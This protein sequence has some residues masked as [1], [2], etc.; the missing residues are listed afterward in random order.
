MVYKDMKGGAVIIGKLLKRLILKIKKFEDEGDTYRSGRPY[1][2]YIGE[3]VHHPHWIDHV[4]DAD[5]R[6]NPKWQNPTILS[7]YSGRDLREVPDWKP[8]KRGFME[9]PWWVAVIFFSSIVVGG[10]I[11]GIMHRAGA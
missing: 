7:N 3:D 6:R 4:L 5:Y 2:W 10:L 11:W 9:G 1:L 8:G